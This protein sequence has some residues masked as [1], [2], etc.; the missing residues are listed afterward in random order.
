[1]NIQNL[2]PFGSLVLDHAWGWV[3][4]SGLSFLECI[5][6]RPAI[7]PQTNRR[8]ER[9][10]VITF[11]VVN[12]LVLVVIL[13]L[14]HPGRR[15]HWAGKEARRVRLFL[16]TAGTDWI[17]CY[18]TSSKERNREAQKVSEWK[19]NRQAIEKVKHRCV[20]RQ[21]SLPSSE[22]AYSAFYLEIY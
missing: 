12:V 3:F 7:R 14:L 22:F 8:C 9:A 2:Q 19:R 17:G 16:S 6:L 4:S 15:H 20:V 5:L 13:L 10:A 11:S 18:P 1:M 21:R